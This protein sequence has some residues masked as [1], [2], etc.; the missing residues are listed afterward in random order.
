[1]N[2]DI[3]KELL[4]KQGMELS[5]RQQEQFRTYYHQ[6]I[7]ANEKTNLTRITEEDEVYLKHFYDSLTPIIKFREM[8]SNAESLC[9]VGAGAGFPSVPIKIIY[10]DIK[11]T[12]IDSLGKRLTFLDKLVKQLGL[13]NITLVHSR[14]EDAGRNIKLRE[15]F[16]VVTARAVAR[17]SVL[18]EYC[19]PLVKVG[20]YF[21]ALKGPKLSD[22][23]FEAQ[24]A[25]TILGGQIEKTCEFT[26]PDSMDDR[27]LVAVKKIKKVSNKYPRQ[28]GIPNRKPL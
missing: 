12:I 10:P 11:L 1:M 5:A 22:E 23:L 14:A 15:N 26:L 3:F 18:S 16:E 7:V 2:S 27:T 9:D 17:M 19:L 8:I 24:N 6:L 4:L 25:L 21:V 20:G 28:A 13:D